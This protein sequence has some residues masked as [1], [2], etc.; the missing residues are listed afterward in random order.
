MNII[1]LYQIFFVYNM[2]FYKFLD[3]INCNLIELINIIS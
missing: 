3:I 2:V 1:R